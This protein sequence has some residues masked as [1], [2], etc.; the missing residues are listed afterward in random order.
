MFPVLAFL[1]PTPFGKSGLAQQA[2]NVAIRIH[3]AAS[4]AH[5]LSLRTRN[6]LILKQQSWL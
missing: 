4:A 1:S 2:W 3:H 6:L 5:L